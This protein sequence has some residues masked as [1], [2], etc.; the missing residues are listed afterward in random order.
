MRGDCGATIVRIMRKVAF[1]LFLVAT[2]SFA[3]E[4]PISV[5]DRNGTAVRDLTA[6]NFELLVDGKR[7]AIERAE[8]VPG[9][10][11]DLLVFDVRQWT[12][13]YASRA[14]AAARK[15]IDALQPGDRIAVASIDLAH[16]LRFLTAFTA[17]RALLTAAVADPVNFRTVDALQLVAGPQTTTPAAP[18]E[19][20]LQAFTH[21]EIA[22]ELILVG[23][24]ARSLRFVPGQK[25][26]IFFSDGFDP[27]V[28]RDAR[29]LEAASRSQQDEDYRGFDMATGSGGHV[30]PPRSPVD[31][32]A[33]NPRLSPS[34]SG[35]T[36]QA[37][38]VDQL[39]SVAKRANVVIDPVDTADDTSANGGKPNGGLAII[40][41][42]TGGNVIT[43]A[44]A[45]HAGSRD[46]YVLSVPV[47]PSRPGQFHEVKLRLVNAAGRVIAPS[48][49]FEP[50]TETP[51]E[52]MLANA[53]ILTGAQAE[54]ALHVASLAAAF[55]TSG[56][57]AQVPVVVEIAGKEI[58]AASKT[59]AATLE[60]YTYAFDHDG[61]PR[62]AIYQRV[63]L[64]VQKVRDTLE[65]SGVKYY[66][67]LALPPGQYTV[68]NLVHVLENDQQ[69]YS[70]SSV[71]VPAPSAL[72]VS[73][74]LFVE[75]G[76]QWMMIKGPS[77]DATKA[78]YP[79]LMNGVSFIPTTIPSRQF[80]VMV[81]NAGPSDVT[82]STTPAAKLLSQTRTPTGA[83]F[84][85]EL[86]E[87]T[88]ALNVTVTRTK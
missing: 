23:G 58:V 40:A 46:V 25:H 3:V 48:G 62:D 71:A 72:T 13:A 86:T 5:V 88:S 35:P 60:L 4:I 53:A 47:P 66:A 6:A 34:D 12:P 16:G 38:A 24:L 49:Y 59:P 61:A 63:G 77:H 33:S 54:K 20:P 30:T 42:A 50:G 44:D 2:S 8:F 65:Q 39:A 75:S 64:D 15:W 69:G 84:A 36:N 70:Q 14:Q 56:D 43:T 28:V 17:D 67:T 1:A 9:Q 11:N 32:A 80:V 21:Q 57:R 73:R 19:A 7:Q 83:A 87:P 41:A 74:P 18:S 37:S 29:A 51:I 45:G 68:R 81:E 82:I 79:F 85:Y 52:R 10:R 31:S 26:L 55:P 22:R 78:P 76:V 27:R